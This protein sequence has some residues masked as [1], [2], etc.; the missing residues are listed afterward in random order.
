VPPAHGLDLTG[1]LASALIAGLFL[2][3]IATTR[4][5]DS[6]G[7]ATGEP[8]A[9]RRVQAAQ[10]LALLT[11]LLTAWWDGAPGLVALLPLWAAMLGVSLYR[12]AIRLL[13]R[14]RQP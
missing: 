6:V 2:A 5:L 11:G 4:Q 14:D 10:V 8:L 3:V 9:A 12:L 1:A 13:S 7:D